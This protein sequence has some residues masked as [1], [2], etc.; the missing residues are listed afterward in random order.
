QYENAYVFNPPG[1][2]FIPS[3]FYHLRDLDGDYIYPENGDRVQDE[4]IPGTPRWNIGRVLADTD[5]DGYTDAYWET[6]P[7]P[8]ENGIRQIVAVSIIDNC[9]MLNAN[10]ATRYM[11]NDLGNPINTWKKTAGHTPV[12]LSLGGELNPGVSV[13]G[14]PLSSN[15]NVGFFD[16]PQHGFY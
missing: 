14:Q 15:W 3:N 2:N 4:F 8:I 13:G 6:A 1:Q 9:A 7:T 5:G 10:V 16:N 11:R 12:D